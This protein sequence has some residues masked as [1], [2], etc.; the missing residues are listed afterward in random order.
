MRAIIDAD[1]LAIACAFTAEEETAGIACSRAG[2]MVERL[3]AD[4]GATEYELWLSGPTNFRKAV[5]P[6]Y[7]ATRKQPRPKWEHE[8]KQ[9]LVDHWQANWS[10][11]VEADD[12]LGIR[13]TTDTILCHQ[14]KDI[15]QI[16]GWHHRWETKRLGTVIKEKQTYSVEPDA[17]DYL[18]FH[19]L[20][21]GDSVDNI[22]GVVGI[23]PKKAAGILYG[24]EN[25][26]QRYE[27]IRD[28]FSCDEELELNAQCVYIWRKYNDSW[29]NLIE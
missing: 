5:Y 18:F 17:G 10:D 11:G 28:L 24:C 21:C 9:Y 16:A 13:Q 19:Q 14:D 8:V 2:E 6:E 27:A 29:R 26:L 4:T 1:Q 23:G 22:K 12:M 25:N 15:N 3:L 7:K 20:L